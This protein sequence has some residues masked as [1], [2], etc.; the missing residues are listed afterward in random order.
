MR[1]S[2]GFAE[3]TKAKVTS[4]QLVRAGV[5]SGQRFNS[6]QALQAGIIDQECD[7]DELRNEAVKLASSKLP[8]KL[9]LARFKGESFRQMKIELY[10][11][12]YR[13]LTKG[14]IGAPPDAPI[15]TPRAKL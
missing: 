5:L 11:D 7:A 4:P 1:L 9:G 10:T 15:G 8:A 3:L 13:A 12:A 6:A 14:R 2:V